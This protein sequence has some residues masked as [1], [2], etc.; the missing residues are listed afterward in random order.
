[1]KIYFIFLL[2]LSSVCYAQEWQ[3]EIMAGVSGY[4]GDLTQQRISIKQLRPA[5]N[6]NI[7]YNSGDFINF[8]GG[9][10]YGRI[11]ADDKNNTNQLLKNRNL[12]FKSDIIEL[13]FITEINLF[14]PETYTS[15]PYVF[16]GLGLFHF[17]P[18]TYDNNNKKVFLR[19]LSTEG[20][21]LKEYPDRKKYKLNQVC[22]PIG[23]GWKW[24]L[25]EK[26]DI[27][28]E[29][30]YRFTFTDYLDDVSTTYVNLTTLANEKG[31]E[32]A[33]LSYR[34]PGPFIDGDVRGNPKTNDIYYFAGIKIGTSLSNIFK[35]N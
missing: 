15:Y 20:E 12:N 23:I 29:F 27:S 4:N 13:N 30:G 16:G 35:K 1:M 2:T 33:A 3:A 31:R 26:W 22:I 6:L 10:G 11:G 34:G 25:N 28:Y 21:G 32:A 5:F 17:N 24:A 7:K 14:D 9:I 8:R 18:F 19:P